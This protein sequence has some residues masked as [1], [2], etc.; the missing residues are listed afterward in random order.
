MPES[1][2]QILIV[3]DSVVYRN[4]LS[5]IV[6]TIPNAEVADAASN[7]KIAL[8]KLASIPI[9][10]VLLDIEMP[11]MNGLD[12]LKIIQ[13]LYPAVQV[14]IVSSVNKEA[15][16]ITIQ[17]LELGAVDF[18]QKP[19]GTYVENF[20][21]LTTQLRRLFTHFQNLKEQRKVRPF[22]KQPA[23]I[24]AKTS[25]PAFTPTPSL[26]QSEQYAP[27]PE[28][29]QVVAVG[30]STGGPNALIKILSKLPADLGVPVLIVQHMPPFFTASL[31]KSLNHQSSLSVKEAE[32]DELIQ[33]NTVY[34]APGGRHMAV[35][36][37]PSANGIGFSYSV[38]IHDE[39]PENGCRPSA[40]VLFR[41][42]AETYGANLMAVVMTGMGS[43]GREGVRAMKRKGCW[44]LTQNEASCVVYGMPQAVVEAGLSD[45]TVSLDS[46]A[47]RIAAIIRG[48]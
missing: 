27:R 30:S 8:H 48:N 17:A 45:E 9:D 38:Q 6:E 34:L 41:S 43:D 28:R 39:A 35:K 7:G 22:P 4:I 19:E 37:K 14:V 10:V 46:L 1:N 26:L 25:H 5:M 18:I 29:I 15:A 36:K 16:M 2:L 40:D 23:A 24:E 11:V 42:I 21:V 44:C 47:E 12:A 32:E 13:R 3:D 33:P 20:G 31:A